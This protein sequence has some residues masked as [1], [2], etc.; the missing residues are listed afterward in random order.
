[1]AFEKRSTLEGVAVLTKQLK[2]LEQLE[3]GQVLKR[4]VKAGINVA[5]KYAR[6]NIPVGTVDHKTYTGRAVSAGFARSQLRTGASINKTKDIA[7]GIL[8][9]T[10]EGYYALNFVELGT[11]Y[12]RAQPWIRKSLLQA[13][14]E[15]EL[16]LA[17][18]I[19]LGIDKAVESA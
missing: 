12:Q 15:A 16:A 1:M 4:G 5:L 18:T 19:L 3:Q 8:T 6:Q 10:K 9:T 7:D 13:R 2:A 11:R 14:D 17:N